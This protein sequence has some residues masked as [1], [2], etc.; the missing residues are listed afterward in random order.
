MPGPARN[1]PNPH[2]PRSIPHHCPWPTFQEQGGCGSS[3]VPGTGRL[4]QQRK[5]DFLLSI[6]GVPQVTL[7]G[8]LPGIALAVGLPI[9]SACRSACRS[10]G[11]LAAPSRFSCDVTPCISSQGIAAFA[12]QRA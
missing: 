4:W 1:L 10:S 5:A 2:S 8:V 12:Y 3:P 7:L 9:L 11:A 6:C